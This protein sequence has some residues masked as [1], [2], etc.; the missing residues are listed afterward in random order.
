MGTLASGGGG[1]RRDEAR[2][3]ELECVPPERELVIVFEGR[4]CRRDSTV[5]KVIGTS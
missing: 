1:R 5:S 2:V 4:S 3:R